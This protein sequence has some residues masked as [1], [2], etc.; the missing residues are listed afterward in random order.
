[1]AQVFIQECVPRGAEFSSRRGAGT[2][3]ILIED[4][5]QHPEAL[6]AC[7]VF[8]KERDLLATR[9]APA[10]PEVEQD[11]LISLREVSDAAART[12]VGEERLVFDADR[13]TEQLTRRLATSQGESGDQCENERA[14]P[15]FTTTSPTMFGCTVQ[16][17]E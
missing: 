10:P 5:N 16:M 13:S 7:V 2:G 15:H 6:F 12:R 17:K 4:A 11:S 14:G 1:M 3:R 8:G 9:N